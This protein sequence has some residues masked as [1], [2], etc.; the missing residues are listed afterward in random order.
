MRTLFLTLF[1]LSACSPVYKLSIPQGN[2]IDDDKLA[3]VKPGMT[4]EQVRYLLG[5]PLVINEF[6]PERWDYVWYLRQPGGEEK[7]RTI[8]VF[9]DGGTVGRVTD[10]NPPVKTEDPANPPPA[11]DA[12]SG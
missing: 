9:F 2:V 11:A 12:Q 10:S 6:S 5:T 3:E 4:P 7:R 1:L 8:S